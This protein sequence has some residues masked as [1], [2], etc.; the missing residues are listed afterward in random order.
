MR[1]SIDSQTG[2]RTPK[3]HNCYQTQKFLWKSHPVEEGFMQQQRSSPFWL[4]GRI[5]SIPCHASYFASVDLKEYEEFNLFFQI[6][7]GKTASAARSW[8]NSVPQTD[9]TTF[10]FAS[11]SILLP[12]EITFWKNTR[13]AVK[14]TY[15]RWFWP[16]GVGMDQRWVQ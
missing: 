3:V 7:W 8:M 13:R 5:Y 11:L 1:R 15:S 4:G 16:V 9:A 14:R 12:W 2:L 6:D 10:A